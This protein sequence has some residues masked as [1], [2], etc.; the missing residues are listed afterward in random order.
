MQDLFMTHATACGSAKL[1]WTSGRAEG[2]RSEVKNVIVVE[3]VDLVGEALRC[4]SGKPTASEAC[5][6]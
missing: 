6:C 5:M 2:V 4:K 3:W 1:D